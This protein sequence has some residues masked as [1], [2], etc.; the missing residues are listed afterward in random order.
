MATTAT[1]RRAAAPQHAPV[2]GA[3]RLR[4][5]GPPRRQRRSWPIRPTLLIA[6]VLVMG[7]LLFVAGAQAYLT[8]QSVRLG[9]VQTQLATQVGEHRTLEMRV[10]QLS[11]PSHVVRT[12]QQHG[13][14]VPGQVTDLPLVSVPGAQA[15]HRARRGGHA[16]APGA[17]GR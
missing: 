10:A 8:Q 11:N 13:L 16:R 14:I 3:P 2:A 15:T 9:H 5:V 4:V 7:S 17:G 6:V 12:A 1:S